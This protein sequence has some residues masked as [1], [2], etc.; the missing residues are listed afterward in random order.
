MTDDSK[1][2]VTHGRWVLEQGDD[3]QW[4]GERDGATALLW[5]ETDGMLTVEIAYGS[6]VCRGAGRI[7]SDAFGAALSAASRQET[8]ARRL[9]EA[10][11]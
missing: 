9:W 2:I 4:R 1:P 7:V 8:D 11:T 3:G 10:L 5:H 6:A